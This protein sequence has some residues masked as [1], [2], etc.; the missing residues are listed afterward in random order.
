MNLLKIDTRKIQIVISQFSPMEKTYKEKK[1]TKED[2]PFE[3][4]I[5]II[6]Y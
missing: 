6:M 1:S 5:A 3:G 4:F 2:A